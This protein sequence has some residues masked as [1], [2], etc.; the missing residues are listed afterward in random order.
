MKPLASV[1]LGTLFYFSGLSLFAQEKRVPDL[2]FIDTENNLFTNRDIPTENPFM[3]IY[4]RTDCDECRHMAQALKNDAK[5]YATTIWMVSP[6]D[7]ETLS[8]FEY[9]T[10]LLQEQNIHILQ[11]NQKKMHQWFNFSSLPFVV[12]FDKAGNQ[13]ATFTTLPDP[14][15]VAEKLNP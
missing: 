12:L 1:L 5:N 14:K 15:T 13:V 2:A 4:F 7:I 8:T 10:G 3:L 6:N 11:D 9:M